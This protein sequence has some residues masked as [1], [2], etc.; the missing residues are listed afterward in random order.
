MR[1]IVA[2]FAVLLFL[3][4]CPKK[5]TNTVILGWHAE[6][7]WSGQCYHPKDF[8]TLG[9]GDL[10]EA[11]EQ[12][13]AA[14]MGQWRGERNDGIQFDADDALGVSMEQQRVVALTSPHVLAAATFTGLSCN[15]PMVGLCRHTAGYM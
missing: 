4:A 1:S 11:R 8:A 10:Y 9:R 13:M 14:M 3:S 6:E 2:P 5:T 12:T 15:V 7:E